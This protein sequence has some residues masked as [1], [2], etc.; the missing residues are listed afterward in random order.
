MRL[1]Q[2]HKPRASL[3]I[4]LDDLWAY[5]KTH[6]DTGWATLPSY[7]DSFLPDFLDLLDR[8]RLRITFFVVGKDAS[9][10]R[11]KELL[12][13]V[14]LRGHEIANHS[15]N[16]EPH[17]R[18]FDSKR[19]SLEV[20]Q[21]AAQICEATGVTPKGFRGPGF[22]WSTDLLNHLA[23]KGYLYDASAFPTYI[24]PIARAHYL[25]NSNMSEQ[26][27]SAFSELFGS[28]TEGFRPVKPF[29][30]RLNGGREL[31]ETPVTTIPILKL[32]FHMT[33]LG[34][35]NGF[36]PSF[37]DLYLGIA[38]GACRATGTAPSF[39]LHPL[40]FL[41]GDKVPQL[42][43]FPGMSVTSVRKTAQVEKV[44]RRFTS[45]F[46][47]GTLESAAEVALGGR[48]QRLKAPQPDAAIGCGS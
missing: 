48:V 44:L 9:R 31:L 46:D 16:H 4:D 28:F 27:K 25:S 8:H 7:L 18:R 24:G 10:A 40:D 6:R 14:V 2:R 37:A 32:P 17:F 47:V 20:D 34:F 30:W 15:F 38:L 21:A 42:S 39:L 33:Y 23:A 5:M 43:Y 29:K 35:L 13:E 45:K 1:C 41:G 26:E 36:V 12:R 3:S 22:S 11:N 19:I